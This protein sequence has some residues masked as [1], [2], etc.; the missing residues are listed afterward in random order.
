MIHA[1]VEAL[2]D[3]LDQAGGHQVVVVHGLGVVADG[4]RV[5]HDDEARCGCRVRARPAG[6]PERAAGCGRASGSAAWSR[7]STLRWTTSQTA[8]A[9]M[10]MR[11]MGLSAT[12]I[13][14]APAS[15]RSEAPAM[16]LVRGKAARRVH[17]HADGELSFAQ[18]LRQFAWAARRGSAVLLLGWQHDHAR[19]AR[20]GAAPAPAHGG[21]VLG[22]GAAAAA[23]DLRAGLAEGEGIIAEVIRIRRVHDAPADLLGPA[24]VG[25]DP[26]AARR[27]QRRASASECAATGRVRRNS[28]RRSRPHRPRPSLRATLLRVVAQQGAVIAREGHRGHHRQGGRPRGRPGW[29]RGSRT[30]RSWSRSRS[31]PR[32]RRTAPRS[33]RRKPPRACFGLDAPEGGDAHAQRADIPGHQHIP[34]GGSHHPPGQLHAGLVDVR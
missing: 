31:G 3:E 7:R 9:D 12:L 25:L 23:D 6:R 13:T 15:C 33:A 30:G 28:S 17:L 14:S 2:L 4:G 11:A 16:Q 27:A 10:R 32:R 22:G 5:A 21:D 20:P 26:E 18:F 24:G 29:P 19:A 34:E 1:H 8:Q